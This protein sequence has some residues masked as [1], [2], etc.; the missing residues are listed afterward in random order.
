MKIKVVIQSCTG[1]E[2]PV[3]KLLDSIDFQDHE[4]DIILVKNNAPKESV[5]K[6]LVKSIDNIGILTVINTPK[7]LWEW[8]SFEKVSEHMENPSI[9]N[10]CFLFVHD[11]T[12]A[13]DASKFWG[14]IERFGDAG[15]LADLEKGFCYPFANGGGF[16]I[17]FGTKQFVLEFGRQFVGQTF[18]KREGILLEHSKCEIK[19]IKGI[20][21]FLPKNLVKNWG[22]KLLW[23][24]GGHRR[25]QGPMVAG[26]IRR[27]CR[28]I[29][30]LDLYKAYWEVPGNLNNPKS[31]I[32]HKVDHPERP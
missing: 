17:G 21:G 12:W 1:Y 4:D 7:N 8:V 24:N 18:S 14:G 29:P 31:F 32:A 11:T 22:G 13:G 6:E 26:G 5:G 10:E 23:A 28:Y 15:P 30:G 3:A 20:K 16:N 2:E 19:G 27:M 25:R 9:N